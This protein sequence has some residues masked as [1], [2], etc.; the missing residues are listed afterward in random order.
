[1]TSKE[2]FIPGV[3]VAKARPRV[4]RNG[5]AYT[6]KK[7]EDAEKTIR[8]AW[9]RKYG[10]ETLR[11]PLKVSITFFYKAPKSWPKWKQRQVERYQ[12]P[13][14]SKPDTDNL[15]KTVLDALNGVAYKD[16]S[17]V[18]EMF[19]RKMYTHD[20]AAGT[21]VVIASKYDSEQDA[22]GNRWYWM[23]EGKDGKD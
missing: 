17:A 21:Q 22:D 9:N 6:P 10:E 18:C 2:L 7:T 5:Y 23:K 3:P 14:V 4:M 12:L 11:G 19:A 16:D 20:G 8:A 1:M 13:K 15:A